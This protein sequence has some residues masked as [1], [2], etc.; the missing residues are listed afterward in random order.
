MLRLSRWLSTQVGQLAELGDFI[1]QVPGDDVVGQEDGKP[2][3]I[4]LEV[5]FCFVVQ[6]FCTL[7][8]PAGFVVA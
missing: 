7:H 3:E 1:F 4:F 2:D 6:C 8:Q 5:H